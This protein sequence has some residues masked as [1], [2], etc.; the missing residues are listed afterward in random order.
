MLQVTSVRLQFACVERTL[1]EEANMFVCERIPITQWLW[2]VAGSEK[3]GCGELFT[4]NNH[5]FN[6]NDV[7]ICL[8]TT[9]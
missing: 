3:S 9:P 4:E 1:R 5:C 6:G 2:P 7:L 8:S